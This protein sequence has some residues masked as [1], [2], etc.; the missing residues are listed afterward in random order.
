MG[1]LVQSLR[2]LS[3]AYHLR[4]TSSSDYVAS[5]NETI[6]VARR[7]LNGLSH[8]ILAI[9]V[10]DICD[11]IQCMLV[12]VHFGLQASQIESVREIFFIDL[13]EV[14]VAS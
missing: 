11:Q 9:K 7:L 8:V 10:E 12:I 4:Q 1:Q 6:K 13:A 2:W 5:M 14:F 3:P